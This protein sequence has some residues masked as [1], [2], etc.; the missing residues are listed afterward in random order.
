MH[1]YGCKVDP[2]DHRDFLFSVPDLTLPHVVDLRS[3]FTAPYNQEDLGS[4]T[5]NAAAGAIQFNQIKIIRL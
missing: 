5:A 2:I 4:C 1:K 3:A